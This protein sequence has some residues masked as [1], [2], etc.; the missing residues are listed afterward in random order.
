MRRILASLLIGL[1]NIPQK[2]CLL[3]VRT[4]VQIVMGYIRIQE[5]QATPYFYEGNINEECF[6]GI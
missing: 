6:L 3:G 4:K 5:K 2:V 1:K